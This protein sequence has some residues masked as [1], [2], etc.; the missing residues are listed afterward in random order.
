M[1]NL[2][3][4]EFRKQYPALYHS[5]TYH[6]GSLK[7]AFAEAGLKYCFSEP[8]HPKWENKVKPFLGRMPDTII[9]SAVGV[10]KSKIRKLRQR[11]DIK[12]Y[13]R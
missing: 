3:T 8:K 2:N 12:A 10:T 1:L 9:A 11:L 7:K 5:A 13:N 4:E 6:F